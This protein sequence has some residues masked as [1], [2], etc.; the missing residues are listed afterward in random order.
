MADGLQSLGTLL[1]PLLHCSIALMYPA[2]NGSLELLSIGILE[3][4][5]SEARVQR[6][7]ILRG[8]R[9]SAVVA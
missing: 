9:C 4:D 8:K 6:S 5:P 7:D 1:N 3:T 2:V